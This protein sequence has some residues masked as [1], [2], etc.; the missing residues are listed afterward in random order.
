MPIRRCTV[1][2]YYWSHVCV[3][4]VRLRLCVRA[5]WVREHVQFARQRMWWSIVFTWLPNAN[6]HPDVNEHRVRIAID[7]QTQRFT[8]ICTTWCLIGAC[9]AFNDMRTIKT[10][11]LFTPNMYVWIVH[12]WRGTY[13]ACSYVYHIRGTK[14]RFKWPNDDR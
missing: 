6:P 13:Y 10:P 12:T 14:L 9:Y 11:A 5:C 2:T 3:E 8:R 1:W 7:A 4:C